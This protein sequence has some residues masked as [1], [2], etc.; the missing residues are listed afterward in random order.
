MSRPAFPAM[1][2]RGC[3]EW[4][5]AAVVMAAT[6][7]KLVYFNSALACCGL[8][9]AD[10]A[11]RSATL[12]SLLLLFTPLPYMPR[13]WRFITALALDG[14]VTSLAFADVVHFRFFRDLIS[15]AE[16]SHAWQIPSVAT[17]ILVALRPGDAVY[18]L[19]IIVGMVALL[20]FLRV[21]RRMPA[22]QPS[23]VH[24][25]AAVLLIMGC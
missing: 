8:F 15:I 13:L 5:P 20:C 23:C 10:R 3:I 14:V 4:G 11:M 7:T 2:S 24:R 12:A 17:S 6:W 16:F 21:N 19:D 25:L 22:P 18:Y 1:V 9:P